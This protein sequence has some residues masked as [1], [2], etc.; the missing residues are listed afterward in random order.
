MPHLVANRLGDP[1]QIAIAAAHEFGVPLLDLDAV[2][3]DLDVVKLVD[4]KLL[5]KHRIL[6]ILQRGK[7]LFIAVCDPTNL[8]A[9]DE[10]K[11]QTTL[12]IEAD[13]R[14][15]GQARRPR[16]ARHRS[17]RHDDVEP[18][19]RRRR[20]RPREPRGLGRRRRRRRR[21]HELRHRRRADR[22]V[23][24]QGH[25]RRDQEGRVRHP[26]RALREALPHSLAPGRRADRDRSAARRARDENLRAL[27]G[28]GSARHRRAAHSARRPHQDEAVE[29][30]RHRLPRQHVPHVVRREG[31]L[32][33]ARSRRARSSASTR[34][35]TRSIRS[36]S[37]SPTWRSPTA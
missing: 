22:A 20:L 23:R 3:L 27:E 2:D 21:R 18:R 36:R 37:T 35:A 17:R 11:F 4:E 24:Q 34:S 15:A 26:L 5:L 33:V 9:L 25:G 31:R 29:E 6:P 7:R 1:R 8:Q 19:R 32:P 12:R 30:S 28:H 14:R 10:I 13:R 16:R